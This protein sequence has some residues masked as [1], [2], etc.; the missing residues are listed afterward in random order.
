MKLFKA[1]GFFFC[2][3]KKLQ[4]S[5]ITFHKQEY[6]NSSNVMTVVEDDGDSVMPSGETR[7]LP[8]TII[9]CIHSPSLNCLGGQDSKREGK[10]GG[11]CSQE[12]EEEAG[13]EGGKRAKRNS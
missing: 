4:F 9:E 12:E 7:Q 10:G 5:G 8:A 2:A 6:H 3:N 11:G 1:V 13:A